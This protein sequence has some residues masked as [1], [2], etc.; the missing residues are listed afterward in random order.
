M[1]FQKK[2]FLGFPLPFLQ[3]SLEIRLIHVNNLKTSAK[4][5]LLGQQSNTS[6][7]TCCFGGMMRNVS[8]LSFSRT[9][10][11]SRPF[12]S[13]TSNLPPNSRRVA[14][15]MWTRLERVKGV[16]ETLI[17]SLWLA[18][19]SHSSQWYLCILTRHWYYIQK[20]S[21]FLMCTLINLLK[22]YFLLL[23]TFCSYFERCSNFEIKAI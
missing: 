23:I 6:K 9:S 12:P 22:Q 21:K 7:F 4:N 10:S 16:A 17:F 18:H 1:Y 11:L 3:R 15:V 14:F 13:S 20:G 8:I 5:G 2:Q 19:S